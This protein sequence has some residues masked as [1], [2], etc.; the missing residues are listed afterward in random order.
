[1]RSNLLGMS[2]FT[3][4]R[5]LLALATALLAAAPA[6][7]AAAPQARPTFELREV[8]SPDG[9]ITRVR[10]PVQA[11]TSVASVAAARAAVN[12]VTALQVT[13]P[14]S[15]KF[16]LVV[17]GDGYTSAERA[18][19][20]RHARSKVAEI[21]SVEPFRNYRDLFNVWL[22]DVTSKQSGVD[23]DPSLGVAK[24]TALDMEFWCNGTERL[25]CVDQAKASAAADR[26]PDVDQVLALGNST[27][28]GGAGGGVAT[29]SGGEA[30]SG[31]IAIHELGHSIGELADEYDS[32]YPYGPHV[33][34]APEANATVFPGPVMTELET[35][36]TPWMGKPTPDGGVIGSFM[37]ARYNPVVYYRPSENSIMRSLGRAYNLVGRE[38]MLVAFYKTARPITISSPGG[39]AAGW[40][41]KLTV[42]VQRPRDHALTITWTLDG[43]VLAAAQNATSLNLF[44]LRRSDGKA[45]TV[46]VVVSDRT[47]WVIDPVARATHLTESRSWTVR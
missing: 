31:Q 47:G 43:K 40:T 17:V 46:R 1:M 30:R 38:A 13:G 23:N 9:S 16:D 27:K 5:R 41:A 42:R 34:D 39:S 22:V 18:R 10:M 37:G 33:G 45:H 28:Y 19:F 15:K 20:E 8:F 2:S 11:P 21:F 26:A 29:A 3:G 4:R 25:L 36:W 7:A 24:D 12:G 35:K 44:P 32:P 14:S 6:A